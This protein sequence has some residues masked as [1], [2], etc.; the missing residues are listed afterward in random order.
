LSGQSQGT[1]NDADDEGPPAK[2]KKSGRVRRVPP[3]VVEDSTDGSELSYPDQT[4]ADLSMENTRLQGKI[5]CFDN[6]PLF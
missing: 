3:E 1:D 5:I 6:W 4:D 2:G